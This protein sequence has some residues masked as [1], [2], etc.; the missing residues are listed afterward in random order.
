MHCLTEL[1]HC[2]LLA[3]VSQVF[4]HLLQWKQSLQGKEIPWWTFLFRTAFSHF[5]TQ[6]WKSLWRQKVCAELL[7]LSCWSAWRNVIHLWRKQI[8]RSN[9]IP[10]C[11]EKHC[12]SLLL[13]EFTYDQ[14]KTHLVIAQNAP[15]L[16]TKVLSIHFLFKIVPN[17]NIKPRI[18]Y[19]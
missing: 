2:F 5:Y 18:S 19:C 8:E 14:N 11:L 7:L 16:I 12:I 13:N 1:I 3:V 4:F 15:A 17:Y 10:Q 9:N 6:L